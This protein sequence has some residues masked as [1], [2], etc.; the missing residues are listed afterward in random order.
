MSSVLFIAMSALILALVTRG[1]GAALLMAI[2]PVYMMMVWLTQFAFTMID[3]VANGR[4]EAATA[5]TEML[6]P[7]GDARCWVHPAHCRR[8]R[9]AP[10][11]PAAAAAHAHPG[12]RLAAVSRI[13][14]RACRV[15]PRLRCIQPG[16]D[17]A[18]DQGTGP[19]VPAAAGSNPAGRSAVRLDTALG[20]VERAAL[21]AARAGAAG[22]LCADRRHPAPAAH[23]AGLRAGRKC[24]AGTAAGRSRSPAAAPAHVRRRLRQAARA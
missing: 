16:R 15:Q 21:C 23:A 22:V 11:P 4:R 7:F 8:H 24:G 1:Q 3:D 19:L 17:L 9:P 10:V 18:G 14:R 2:L 5:T 12:R 6:S 20:P 13:H